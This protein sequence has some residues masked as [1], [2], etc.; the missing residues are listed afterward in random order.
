MT[1]LGHPKDFRSQVAELNSPDH[2]MVL[3]PHFLLL[4]LAAPPVG[5]GSHPYG[6]GGRAHV[7]PPFDDARRGRWYAAMVVEAFANKGEG[8]PRKQLGS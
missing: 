3:E 7:L 1:G 6:V 8:G 5:D 2:E 4:F